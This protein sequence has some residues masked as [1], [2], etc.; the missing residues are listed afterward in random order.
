MFGYIIINKSEMKFKEYDIYHSYYCG[1]CR[2]LKEK[3]GIIGQTTLSYDM[4]F[5][6]MLLTGLYEPKTTINSY[7]CVTHPFIKHPARLNEFTEYVADMNI[8]MSYYKCKDDWTDERNL[9][10]LG[11]AKL[12]KPKCKKIELAYSEKVKKVD[13]LLK[14]I[15][16]GEQMQDYDIDKMAG[17]FGGVMAEIFAYR[18]DEWEAGMRRIG[19]YLGKFI[20]LMDAYEDIEEDLKNGTYNPF[21]PLYQTSNYEEECRKILNMMM[22]E[23]SKEFEK[24]PI[25]ENIEII[26]NILYSGVWCRFVAVRKKREEKQ[27]KINE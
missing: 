26:R 24:L 8:L 3:H 12:L 7:K 17:R 21:V 6:H 10:K 9:I 2:K 27:V 22:A 14:D 20:Y 11:Y 5:L 16:S 18:Q 1:L 4:T 23:C 25:L 13:S 15:Y 19:F